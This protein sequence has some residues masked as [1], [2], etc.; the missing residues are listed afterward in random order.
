MTYGYG[1][2]G[3]WGAPGGGGQAPPAVGGSSVCVA[4]RAW[5]GTWW[6]A[7]FSRGADKRI[8][9][10]YRHVPNLGRA[11]TPGRRP[12][13]P[14][15]VVTPWQRCVASAHGVLVHGEETPVEFGKIL[16]GKGYKGWHALRSLARTPAS[17]QTQ[18][19]LS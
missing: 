3:P 1:V 4:A 7:G 13:R 18:L 16:G 12:G 14:W 8:F 9:V 5:R 2:M 17:L 11:C 6:V 15:S 10:S 19:R